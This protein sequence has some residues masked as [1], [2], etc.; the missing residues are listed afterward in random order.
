MRTV[1]GREREL[2][3]IGSFLAGGAGRSRVLMIEGVAGIGKTAVWEAA[4]RAASD[5]GLRVLS[6]RPLEAETRVSFAGAGDLLAGALDAVAGELPGSQR[7]ALEF[8]LLLADPDGPPPPPQ[9]I[10]VAFLSA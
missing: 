5:A 3:A 7:R 8:A 2:E 9:E 10:A 1:V 4:V 6:A